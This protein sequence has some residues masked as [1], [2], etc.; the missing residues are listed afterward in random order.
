M[1]SFQEI[2]EVGY[3]SKKKA[4]EHGEA[5]AQRLNAWTFLT[6]VLASQPRFSPHFLNLRA[7]VDSLTSSEIIS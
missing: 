5:P 3:L 2:T 1:Q 7:R 6:M 4:R